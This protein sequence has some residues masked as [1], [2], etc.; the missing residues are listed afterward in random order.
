M[1]MKSSVQR[2]SCM[3]MVSAVSRLKGLVTS[4]QTMYWTQQKPAA[5]RMQMEY[6]RQGSQSDGHGNSV[7]LASMV[8]YI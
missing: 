1:T 4:W 3:A 7:A 6:L 2:L 5:W 8:C